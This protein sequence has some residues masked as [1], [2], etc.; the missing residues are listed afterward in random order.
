MARCWLCSADCTARDG[1]YRD[2]CRADTCSLRLACPIVGAP[3]ITPHGICWVASADEHPAQMNFL[4]VRLGALG[5]IIHAV[6]AAAALR[7]AF[8]DARIDWL[9]DA[10]HRAMVELVTVVDRAVVLERSTIAG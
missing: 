4:I 5:D 1:L 9:V 3:R 10:K 2:R 7:A 8:P 6:P